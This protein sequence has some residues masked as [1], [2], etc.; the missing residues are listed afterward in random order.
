MDWNS[1]T[2]DVRLVLCTVPD[3]QTAETLARALV[4]EALVACVN[5]VPH[6]RSIYRWKGQL[7]DDSEL[8]L[9]MKTTEPRL[10]SLAARVRQLHPYETPE[11]I[12][13]PIVG[14]LG[15]YVDWVRSETR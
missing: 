8:L 4:T 13:A 12:A 3:Q 9:L 6:V 2:E 11:I 1:E 10:A 5:I 15:A 14:A 7:C